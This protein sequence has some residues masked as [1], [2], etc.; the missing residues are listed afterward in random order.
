MSPEY[1][2]DLALSSPSTTKTLRYLRR[3]RPTQPQLVE[4][5]EALLQGAAALPH[6]RHVRPGYTV[7]LALD[8]ST[9][10]PSLAGPTRPQ[11]RVPAGRVGRSFDRDLPGMVDYAGFDCVGLAEWTRSVE[12]RPRRRT[13]SR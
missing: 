3:H 2:A 9:V 11:D 6:G 10:E 5:V 8:L 7:P 1:G 4:R 12:G 13:W